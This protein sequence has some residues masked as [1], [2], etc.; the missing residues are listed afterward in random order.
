MNNREDILAAIQEIMVDMFEMDP[1]AFT[2][3]ARLYVV[4]FV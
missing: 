3:E 2:L 1:A 4:E